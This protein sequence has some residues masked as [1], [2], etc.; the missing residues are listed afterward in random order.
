MIVPI[1]MQDLQATIIEDTS[2]VS[3]FPTM[4]SCFV[5]NILLA[6][7]SDMVHINQAAVISAC[8][9][10]SDGVHSLSGNPNANGIY[11]LAACMCCDKLLHWFVDHGVS[12]KFLKTHWKWFKANDSVHLDLKGYYLYEGQGSE[13]WMDPSST[14]Y[15]TPF[16]EGYQHLLA[17]VLVNT[18]AHFLS[19]PLARCIIM[20]GS[21]FQYSHDFAQIPLTA[22]LDKAIC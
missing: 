10:F 18:G 7:T 17:L 22:F 8:L 6:L 19:A 13:F 9:G 3:H 16:A 5:V 21:Q 11:K 4:G 12:L 20:N 15:P 14:D 2:I 1:Q